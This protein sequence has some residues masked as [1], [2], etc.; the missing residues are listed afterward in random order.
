MPNDEPLAGVFD[1]LD[2]CSRTAR[3]G[4]DFAV[5]D[6]ATLKPVAFG[7]F[8]SHQFLDAG[9]GKKRI[10][11]HKLVNKV[12]NIAK[13]YDAEVVVGKLHTS[14]TNSGHHFNR[15]VQG[16]NQYA[17][18]EIMRYKL[19]LNGVGYC[20]GNEAYTSTVGAALSKPLGLDVHKASAY[21]FAV[22]TL[23]Y[24]LFQSFRNGMAFLEEFCAD[25][26]DGIPSTGRPGE[27]RLTASRQSWLTRLMCSELSIPL[28]R[29]ATPN[30]G[31][32]GWPTRPVQTHTLQ[33]RV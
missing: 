8:N 4:V 23:D 16:M 14:Y 13:H 31:K 5:A 19:P 10:L 6:K 21:A 2:D 28:L 7:K 1:Y 30:L 9:K 25:E 3:H 22:K 24:M 29:E 33:V 12:R 15:R 26:G 11:A 27:S 32:G 18:R 17:M 20:E